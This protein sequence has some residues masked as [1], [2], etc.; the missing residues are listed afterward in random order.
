MSSSSA[1]QEQFIYAAGT[2]KK[3]DIPITHMDYGYIEQCK[4]VKELE[5]ILKVLR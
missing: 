5:K 4:D 1:K 2:T 3:Y